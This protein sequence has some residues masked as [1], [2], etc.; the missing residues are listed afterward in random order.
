M[1][2]LSVCSLVLLF[3]ANAANAASVTWLADDRDL[4]VLS[5]F[6]EDYASSDFGATTW[7]NTISAGNA[8][9]SQNTTIGTTSVFGGTGE[10]Y[11]DGV[12][13]S[14][15]LSDFDVTFRV[16]GGG[17]TLVLTGDY[18]GYG[19]FGTPGGSVSFRLTQGGTLIYQSSDDVIDY[20]GFLADGDYR[21]LAYAIISGAGFNAGGSGFDFT[22]EFGTSAVTF[23]P[24]PAAVWLF[25]SALVGLGWMRR[26]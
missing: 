12:T 11:M 7:D 3:F 17:T 18:G 24:V 21:I 6:G 16:A 19:E 13:D 8:Y 20:S 1:R 25:G 22:G 9:A 2:K 15:S 5:N 10:V 4:Y 26:R 14:A 23:V